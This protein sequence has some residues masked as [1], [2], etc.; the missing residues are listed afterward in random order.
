MLFR[1][2]NNALSALTPLIRARLCTVLQRWDEAIELFDAF[3]DQGQREGLSHG[4]AHLQVTRAWCLWQVGRVVAAA[5]GLAQAQ[6]GV[7]AQRDADDRA[8]THAR[9]AALSARMGRTAQAEMHQ[10]QAEEALQAHRDD[11]ARMAVQ[12]ARVTDV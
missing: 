10:R 1:S 9:L 5:D 4:Y 11:V 3:M 2:G 6:H 8:G 12:L 7:D